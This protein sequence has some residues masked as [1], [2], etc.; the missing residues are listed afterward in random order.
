MITAKANQ[1]S[2]LAAI[3][4]QFSE[5]EERGYRDREVRSHRT[6]SCTR[7]RIQENVVTVAPVPESIKAMDKF[8]GIRTI[9]R[10][11]RH[12]EAIHQD[13]PKAIKESDKVT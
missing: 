10:V 11:H 8:A 3:E 12:R 13:N 7:G 1:P 2:L 9:G 5:D 6:E 4:K